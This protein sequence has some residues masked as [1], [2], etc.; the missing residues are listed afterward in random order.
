MEKQGGIYV[1][2]S[3]GKERDHT[4]FTPRRHDSPTF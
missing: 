3:P 2:Y 4:H 1:R